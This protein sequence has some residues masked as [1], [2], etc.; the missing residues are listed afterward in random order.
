MYE[1]VAICDV[2]FYPP[3]GE[4]NNIFASLP[5][6]S[7]G[8]VTRKINREQIKKGGDYFSI[9]AKK[10]AVDILAGR[11]KLQMVVKC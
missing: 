7:V 10:H 8:V 1:E 3:T 2:I 9:F 11:E 6:G 4:N 5:S